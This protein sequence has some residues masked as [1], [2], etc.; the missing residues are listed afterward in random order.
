MLR[1]I[2]R[3]RQGH[4]A[5]SPLSLSLAGG[6]PARDSVVALTAGIDEAMLLV[7]A[8]RESPVG[9]RTK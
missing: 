4:R 1:I 3:I 2:G 6:E 8:R 9:E 7:M 5:F